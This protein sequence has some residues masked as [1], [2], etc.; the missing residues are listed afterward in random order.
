MNRHQPTDQRTCL[1]R[2]EPYLAQYAR[3]KFGCDR[4]TGGIRV[5][6]SFSL[7]HCIWHAMAK[8]P[9]ERW[10]VG[11]KRRVD[12][13]EGNL[14]IHLPNRRPEGGMSKNPLYWNYIS[15]RHAY[16][17]GL[18]LKRLF[19]WDFHHFVD[20]LMAEHPGTTRIDAVWQFM[21]RW[22][23]DQLDTD[24]SETLVKNLQRHERA[25]YIAAGLKNHKKR[26]KCVKIT[27]T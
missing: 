13:P 4:Q 22:R 10:H 1:I 2:V 7:Y 27:T 20:D 3:I 6:D 23:L 5:P 24:V 26:K 15:P 18:E 21:K 9:L 16:Y 11:V 8:W 25:L 17:I 19:D 14:L 12:A